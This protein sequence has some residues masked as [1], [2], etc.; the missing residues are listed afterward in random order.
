M[1]REPM[2]RRAIRLAPLP[3]HLFAM[4]DAPAG[5]VLVEDLELFNIQQGWGNAEKAMSCEKKPITLGGVVVPH[6]VGSH[7]PSEI[8][9]DLGG[10]ATRFAALA[11]IDDETNGQG[12]ARFEVW[13][14]GKLRAQSGSRRGGQKPHRFDVDLRGAKRILLVVADAGHGIHMA[15]AEWAGAMLFYEPGKKGAPKILGIDQKPSDVKIAP[16]SKASQEPAIHGPRVV[17]TTPGR[18]FLFLVPATGRGPLRFDAENLPKGLAIDPTTGIITGSVER[19]GK[20]VASLTVKGPRGTATRELRIVAGKNQL[21][22]TP[23]LG[24]NSWNCWADAVDDTKIRQSA[25]ALVKSGL[26]AHGFCYVNIDDCWEGD[27][28]EDG[29]IRTNAKFPDMKA[30]ADHVHDKGLKLGIYSSPGPKTCAGYEGSLGHEAKDAETY[31]DWGCDYLKY[32]WCS[33]GPVAEKRS[34]PYA[35]KPYDVMKRALQG[36]DRDI[37]YSLCQYGMADV[38]KW[39]ARAGG[40]LWRTTGDIADTWGSMSG[41]GFTQN[42]L[43]KFAGPSHWNDPDMLVVGRVGWG[44]KLHLT[45]LSKNEQVTHMTLWAILAAPL[46]IGCDLAL[47]DT[48]TLDLLTNDDVLDVNQDP[49]GRQGRRIAKSGTTEIWARELEDGTRAVGLF[50]RG[51]ERA[52]I[53]MPFRLLGLRAAQPVRDLWR[54]KDVGVHR[55]AYRATVGAHGAAMVRIGKPKA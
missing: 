23:P 22:L 32:D 52:D 26:A 35:K 46:L 38:W 37:V 39:G 12:S 5:A 11:G 47:L 9:I 36:V 42:G 15:H 41:I 2:V 24:W 19:A 7:S 14:D 8:V 6:G 16:S 28:D 48:F 30:L 21:A 18:P 43:E 20:T 25:D 55:V 10:P 33:Y 1:L 54:R 44:P 17:G 50:N 31:A 3:K 51:R 40:N 4:A 34:V 29:C 13:V 45:R 53:I 49:L 27:R